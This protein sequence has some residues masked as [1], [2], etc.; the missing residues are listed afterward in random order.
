MLVNVLYSLFRFTFDYLSRW[1]WHSQ[2]GHEQHQ[3]DQTQTW[4]YTWMSSKWV[5][6]NKKLHTKKHIN[7]NKFS[8][9][10]ITQSNDIVPINQK[11]TKKTWLFSLV[12][13][14][15]N[16]LYFLI[17]FHHSVISKGLKHILKGLK[18]KQ[19]INFPH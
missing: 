10:E 6:S 7:L 15:D 13:V 8:I 3:M 4:L 11:F 19:A 14:N 5:S 9:N 17:Q 16:F 12:F 18:L 2:M 1:C